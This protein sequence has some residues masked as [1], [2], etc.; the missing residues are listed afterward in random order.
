MKEQL[1]ENWELLNVFL[2]D[3]QKSYNL[4]RGRLE[5]I[6]ISEKKFKVKL[7]DHERVLNFESSKED[8]LLTLFNKRKEKGEFENCTFDEFKNL[9]EEGISIEEIEEE[10]KRGK[11]PFDQ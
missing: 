7:N 6:S 2:E 5:N 1:K 8:V 3:I 4:E 11:L 9:Y 10:L